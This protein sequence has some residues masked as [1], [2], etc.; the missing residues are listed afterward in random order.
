MPK[1]PLTWLSALFHRLERY[2]FARTQTGDSVI[3][4][5]CN[6]KGHT[7]WQGRCPACNALARTRLLPFSVRYF[8]DLALD[9]QV[10]LHLG[11]NPQ[12]ARWI[13]TEWN[14]YLY[15]ATDI[16]PRAIL[17]LIAD[18]TQL[19]IADAS[20]D[21]VIGWHVLE[22]IPNDRHAIGEILRVL[23]PG[24]S[25]LVSVPI[26]PSNREVTFEDISVPRAEYVTVYGHPDHV[27]ACGQDYWKRFEEA[28]FIV[29]TLRVCDLLH[30]P[31]REV[32]NR[33]QLNERHI[34]WYC[35]KR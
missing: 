28:G 4:P 34:V 2:W 15:I 21:V 24:G 32:V 3:C 26:W 5:I 13:C 20:V 17:N 6:W 7:F 11:P 35:K 19:A 27:R 29:E 31:N 22:H 12:E 33:Y 30:T 8:S 25:F 9:N 18:A 14:P 23:K 16:V 1:K 10:I